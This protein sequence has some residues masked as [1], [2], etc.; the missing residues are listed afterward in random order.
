MQTHNV[1]SLATRRKLHAAGRR[2]KHSL[3]R[4]QFSRLLLW[5]V[6]AGWLGGSAYVMWHFNPIDAVSASLCRAVAGSGGR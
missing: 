4:F 1:Y 3:Q 6:I 2:R 5:L